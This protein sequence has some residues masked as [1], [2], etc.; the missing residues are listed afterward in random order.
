[1]GL[2]LVVPLNSA[3]HEV[4]APAEGT[5]ASAIV[6]KAE[7]STGTANAMARK[8]RSPNEPAPPGQPEAQLPAFSA[9]PIVPDAFQ[10]DARVRIASQLP[11]ASV[12]GFV[13]L[14][15][16]PQSSIFL[17]TS[18]SFSVV[19]L[20]PGVPGPEFA[21][22]G[23]RVSPG[24]VST[25]ATGQVQ[26]PAVPL[27]AILGIIVCGAMIYGL[28]WTNWLRLAGWL[29]VGLMIYFAYGVKHSRLESNR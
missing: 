9:T 23:A 13:P 26:S 25:P 6:T 22:G 14:S 4:R 3:R 7:P 27:V 10:N 2:R 20:V 21:F 8:A 24:V 28:G 19:P 18:G 11:P 17:S 5:A 12:G 16:A 29:V 1:M 15:P